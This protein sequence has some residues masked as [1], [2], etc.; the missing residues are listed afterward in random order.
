MKNPWQ[1]PKCPLNPVPVPALKHVGI[2]HDEYEKGRRAGIEEAARL[3]LAL[4]I[5][6]YGRLIATK[7]GEIK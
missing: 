4:D 3:M 1:W 7:I 2:G 6:G 5:G